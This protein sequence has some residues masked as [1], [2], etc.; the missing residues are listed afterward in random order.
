MT[1]CHSIVLGFLSY[2]FRFF[3]ERALQL[4]R[5]RYVVFRRVLDGIVTG[6]FTDYWAK[7]EMV[8]HDHHGNELTR[9]REFPLPNLRT[10]AYFLVCGQA[11]IFELLDLQDGRKNEKKNIEMRREKIVTR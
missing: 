9:N 6:V 7:F 5:V 1:W 2:F 11:E 4:P 8:V 10:S 3:L